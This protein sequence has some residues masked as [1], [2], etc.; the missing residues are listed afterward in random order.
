MKLA[1][2][3]KVPSVSDPSVEFYYVTLS[4]KGHL[5]CTCKSFNF[6]KGDPDKR[7][8]KHTKDALAGVWMNGARIRRIDA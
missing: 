6:F 2:E 3:F 8:C 1:L 4:P 5:F 7:E